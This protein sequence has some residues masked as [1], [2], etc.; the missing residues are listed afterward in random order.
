MNFTTQRVKKRDMGIIT[1]DDNFVPFHLKN[2]NCDFTLFTFMT[3]F[4]LANSHDLDR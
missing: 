4:L 1:I 2:K 3:P